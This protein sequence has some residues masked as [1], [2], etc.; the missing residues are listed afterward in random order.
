METCLNRSMRNI[1]RTVEESI[2]AFVDIV[3]AT[4]NLEIIGTRVLSDT[5]IP[6]EV[7]VL[8]DHNKEDGI[9]GRYVEVSI[10]EIIRTIYSD[11]SLTSLDRAQQMSSAILCERSD[12]V[13][14][15]ITRIVGYYSRV[16]NWNKSKRGE[17]R[18]RVSSRSDGGYLLTKEKPVF[19][20]EALEYVSNLK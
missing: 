6:D 7:F 2:G 9:E 11:S 18:D 19:T 15:G 1:D 14:H 8:K 17:L 20:D 5:A 4:E 16:T 10:S 3:E 13:L 12:I